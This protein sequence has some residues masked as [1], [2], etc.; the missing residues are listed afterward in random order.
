MIDHQRDDVRLVVDHKHAL[1]AGGVLAH[2]WLKLPLSGRARQH[3]AC[4]E[5][6]TSGLPARELAN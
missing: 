6:V 4:H 1:P 5:R 2:Q 3:D